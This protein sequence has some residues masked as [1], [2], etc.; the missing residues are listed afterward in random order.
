MVPVKFVPF[1]HLGA[2]S[3]VQSLVCFSSLMLVLVMPLSLPLPFFVRSPR[4]QLNF[5]L[6]ICLFFLF[7]FFFF[8]HTINGITS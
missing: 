3:N 5:V 7:F 6:N 8:D 4:T 2:V 1:S